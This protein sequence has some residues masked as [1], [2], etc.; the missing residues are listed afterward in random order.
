MKAYVFPPII[1]LVLILS[2]CQEEIDLELPDVE[3]ELVV[4]AY[5]TDLDF[6]IPDSDLDCSGITTF[7]RELIVA[8]ASLA[9]TF[10]VDSAEEVSDYFP[11]NKVVLTSTANYFS[12][13]TPP[14]V[15]DATVELY[16]DGNLVETLSHDG[17]NPGTY[18]ITHDPVVGSEYHLEIEA[19]GKFYETKKETYKAVPPLI[20]LGANYGP[21]FI[22]DSCAYY[23]GIDTY[24]KAGA[25]DF[26]RWF[27]YINGKYDARPNFITLSTDDG[28]DGLCLFGL[29]V[30]GDELEL[31]DTLTVF[32]MMTS[33]GYYNFNVAL[34]SRTGQVGSP[35]DAPPSPI[36]GNVENI[37]DN[38]LAIG[39]FAAGGITANFVVVPDEV[40]TGADCP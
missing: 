39:F 27:F 38:K 36:S 24:E 9:A 37:T 11:F 33:E 2:G 26:Y 14:P 18:P 30:Y 10:P 7:P 6:F 4:E 34:R 5:L 25:G 23:L 32:Q 29:D 3:P 28:I 40:P 20:G 8:G 17:S 21:N 1:A 16:Q 12:N 13:A 15:T 19:L 31:G 22:Q 35:F